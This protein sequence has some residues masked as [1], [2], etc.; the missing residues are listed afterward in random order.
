MVFFVVHESY[1]SGYR[2]SERLVIEWKERSGP[3]RGHR[4]ESSVAIVAIVVARE[5]CLGIERMA[6]LGS[7]GFGPGTD[8]RNATREGPRLGSRAGTLADSNGDLLLW[9][10]DDS[11]R[12]LFRG[13][14]YGASG[15]IQSRSRPVD[16]RRL[17]D[18]AP[19]PLDSRHPSS[20]ARAQMGDRVGRLCDFGRRLRQLRDDSGS[21]SYPA[22]GS[23]RTGLS[24]TAR[25]L[26][27]STRAAPI[28]A[29]ARS[30]ARIKRDR[31]V[32]DPKAIDVGLGPMKMKM[33]MTIKNTKRKMRCRSK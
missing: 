32:A 23:R 30:R 16:R 2:K 6:A 24:T 22:R 21:F 25:S 13:F 14:R 17:A 19:G 33:K 31:R 3:A 8:S 28:R 12:W 20:D 1:Q 7:I 9:Y 5:G 29:S 10:V 26:A 18:P 4:G 15:R 27:R 11:W